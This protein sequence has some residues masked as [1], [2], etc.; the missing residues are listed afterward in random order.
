MKMGCLIFNR[1]IIIFVQG[2][3]GLQGLK[4]EKGEPGSAGPEVRNRLKFSFK[5]LFVF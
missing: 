5:N 3:D 4:G 1:K 2:I